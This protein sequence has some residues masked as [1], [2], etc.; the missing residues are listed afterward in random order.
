MRPVVRESGIPGSAR[1]FTEVDVFHQDPGKFYEIPE[2]ESGQ[3]GRFFAPMS[4]LFTGKSG[5]LGPKTCFGQR[6][7]PDMGSGELA[8][9]RRGIRTMLTQKKKK[10]KR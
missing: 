7:N 4:D 3:I 2:P 10:K 9:G 6:K 8:S 1:S 5:H